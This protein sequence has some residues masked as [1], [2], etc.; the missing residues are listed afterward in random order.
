MKVASLKLSSA[1][2]ILILL[3]FSG[4]SA[5]DLARQ[6]KA[7]L[8]VQAARSYTGVPYKFG[9]TTRAGMDCSALLLHSFKSVKV[10]LPRV[11]RDQAKIGEKVKLKDLRPGDMVFF[12]TGKKKN[13]ITHAGIVTSVSGKREIRFIHASTKLGVT[14]SN[15]LSN[16]YMQR[17]KR[18]RRVL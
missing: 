6:R 18:A 7:Q 8:V 1:V 13:E 5:G 4:C 16:Y 3:V 15:L 12:A 9:G 17:F 14:E 10:N 11:S 2:F